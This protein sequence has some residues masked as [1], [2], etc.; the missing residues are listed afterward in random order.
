MI[1]SLKYNLVRNIIFVNE[2]NKDAL[3]KSDVRGDQEQLHNF[4]HFE[5]LSSS[6]QDFCFKRLTIRFDVSRAL[7]IGASLYRPFL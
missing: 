2:K 1:F 5:T 6:Y 3:L 4:G 7:Y